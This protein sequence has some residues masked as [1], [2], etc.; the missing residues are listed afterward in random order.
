MNI[1]HKRLRHGGA[2]DGRGGHPPH[3]HS[4]H[5]PLSRRQLLGAAGMAAG[6]LV[7]AG[8][9]SPV[10]AAVPL[11]TPL[12]Q[13]AAAQVGPRL[14]G[15]AM[16]ALDVHARRFAARNVF[17]VV[18]FTAGSST[19][20]FHLVDLAGG[21]VTTVLVA[22]GRGSDPDHS[23][24]VERFSNQPGSLASS[25]GAYVTGD[26]YDGKHGR[27]RRLIGLDPGNNNAEARALVI[28]AAWYVGPD[29]V[30]EHGKLGRSEGCFAV[31]ET[32]LDRVLARLP[33]GTMLYADKV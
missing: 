19:P 15:R 25:A 6:G 8:M 27:S 1:R 22:H 10:L 4:L 33:A 29:M 16:R 23:G 32:D 20:R 9:A 5:A 26:I 2:H 24:W 14:L 30:R 31:A 21:A 3:A 18:D 7:A 28:H 12:P 17:G 13:A 11:P